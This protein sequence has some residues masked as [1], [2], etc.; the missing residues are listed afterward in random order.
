MEFKHKD[1]IALRD[2]SKEE[3]ELL[4][5]TAENMREVNSRDI[6]KVPTLRARPSSICSTNHPPVPVPRLRLPA[7]GFLQIRSI[8]PLPT[9]L[10]L[11]GRPWPTQL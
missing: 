1:I 4:I 5:S 7:S 10:P 3:I 8:L 9:A 6:K 11:K 2:L